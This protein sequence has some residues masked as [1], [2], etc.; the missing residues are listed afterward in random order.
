MIEYLPTVDVVKQC[1]RDLGGPKGH[2][3]GESPVWVRDRHAMQAQLMWEL[4]LDKGSGGQK[5][6]R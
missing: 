3:A 1:K 4:Y 5:R 2:A 6:E